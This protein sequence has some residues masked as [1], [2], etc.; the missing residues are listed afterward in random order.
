[1]AAKDRA[2]DTVQPL[3]PLAVLLAPSIVFLTV[4]VL[5]LRVGL[6]EFAKPLKRA[7]E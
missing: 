4:H 7:L 1:M 2:G 6:R 5:R 3:H